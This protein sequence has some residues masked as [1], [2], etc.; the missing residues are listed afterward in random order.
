MPKL[1]ADFHH[2]D[3]YNSLLTLFEQRLGWEVYRPIGT[4][5]HT[6][7]YWAVYD[8]PA[9]AAQYL[10]VGA[11]EPLDFDG[12]PITDKQGDAA[13]LNRDATGS[14]ETGLYKIGKHKAMTFKRATETK[15][16]AVLSSMPQHFPR[17]EKFVREFCPTA[18]HIFQQGNMWAVPQGVRNHLN[19]TG[20]A[21]LP[22]SN[23]VRY[24]PE[25]DLTEYAR[26]SCANRRTVVNLCHY[27]Q[28]H[29]QQEFYELERIMTPLGWTFKNHG[30]GNRD[31]ASDNVARTIRDAGFVWHNK[32]GGE[33]YGFNAHCA[34]AIGRPLISH[35]SIYNGMTIQSLMT[36]D[37]STYINLDDRSLTHVAIGLENIVHQ[38]LHPVACN[39]TASNFRAIVDFDAEA[40]QIKA[41]LENLQ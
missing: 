15:W 32:G 10:N 22:G 19:S 27:H 20:V 3:L 26:G 41:F 5:W 16:D 35:R 2:S 29:Y 37:G 6:A 14:E 21:P 23:H 40:R 24:H 1:L 12:N 9:T 8:H 39:D 11:A 30:A 31:G 34:A 25:F 36:V 17:Y 18:K 33:G 7:G 28:P 13:W 38:G 4:E